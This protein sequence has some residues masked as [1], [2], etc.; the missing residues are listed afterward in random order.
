MFRQEQERKTLTVELQSSQE[1]PR[2][3]GVSTYT[4]GQDEEHPSPTVLEILLKAH[5]EISHSCGGMG[6]CGT[7]RIEVMSSSGGLATRNE[8]ET[9]F[10][11]ERLFRDDERLA[12]QICLD[13]DLHIRVPEAQST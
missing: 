8:V 7:C 9:D 6:T 10:A 11:V 12:C 1:E 2:I 13:S 5:I 3:I 4:S